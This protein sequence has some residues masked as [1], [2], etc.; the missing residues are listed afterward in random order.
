LKLT[1]KSVINQKLAESVQ[2]YIFCTSGLSEI[3][4]YQT[5]PNTNLCLSVYRKNK[6]LHNK[7]TNF[8]RVED[9]E[10]LFSS[11]LWGFHEKIF[12]VSI[13]AKIDQ[14]CILFHPGAIRNFTDVPYEI[15]INASNVFG[16][17]FGEQSNNFLEQLFETN[18]LRKRIA[19]LEQFLCKRM[20]NI[21]QN[22]SLSRAV[23][24][25]IKHNG[26]IKIDQL[27]KELGINNS[28]LYRHFINYIGQSPKDF[29]KTVRFRSALFLL[30]QQNIVSLTDIG[31]STNYYDQSHFIKEF[32]HFTNY[33]PKEIRNNAVVEQEKLI[34][35]N[36]SE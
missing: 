32:L 35:V 31:Y 9:G 29:I 14:V 33:T 28:T 7:D 21:N 26:N 12:N 34:W 18:D 23:Q 22:K 16:I 27:S 19:L 25:V 6:V 15:L 24:Q 8:C 13:Q 4:S 10:S 36:N 17:I 1:I 11:K 20:V 30:K 5:F 3:V 2:Y